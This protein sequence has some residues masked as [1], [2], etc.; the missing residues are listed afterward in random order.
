MK[1]LRN[2]LFILALTQGFFAFSSKANEDAI[3][4]KSVFYKNIE[5]LKSV[6]EHLSTV[7]HYAEL[8]AQGRLVLLRK[9]I[10]DLVKSI[11]G[12]ILEKEDR[13]ILT[14]STLWDYQYLIY[15]FRQ[16][17]SFF[18]ENTP[19]KA[20]KNKEAIYKFVSEKELEFGDKIVSRINYVVFS[21]VER[22]VRSFVKVNK[23]GLPEDIIEGLNKI[24]PSLGKLIAKADAR[25]DVPETWDSAKEVLAELDIYETDILNA[26]DTVSFREDVLHY[27]GLLD[28]YKDLID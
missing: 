4:K 3:L 22:L 5:E 11:K 8:E 1:L 23:G 19:G 26:V 13:T 24:L 15:S 2:L 18:E 20:T 28:I 17:E 27:L 25:G 7:Q 21:N 10:E 12:E 9:T 14:A 6:Q 16:S